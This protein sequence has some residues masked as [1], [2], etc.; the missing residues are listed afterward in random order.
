MRRKLTS[1]DTGSLVMSQKINRGILMPCSKSSK[2]H[3]LVQLCL[4]ILRWQCLITRECTVLCW[5]FLEQ[6][7]VGRVVK[8]SQTLPSLKFLNRHSITHFNPSQNNTYSNS[9]GI[10]SCHAESY[11]LP[12][13]RNPPLGRQI[14]NRG[15]AWTLGQREERVGTSRG[16]GNSAPTWSQVSW[17]STGLGGCICF[18]TQ[19]GLGFVR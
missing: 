9:I 12:R 11:Q 13:Y 19:W 4:V 7:I 10:R 5:L 15:I 1:K 3:F 2:C 14:V 16:T 18:V 6:L 8:F 17:N